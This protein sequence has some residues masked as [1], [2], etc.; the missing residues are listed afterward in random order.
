MVA[1]N[2]VGCGDLGLR[3]ALLEQ[4][5]KNTV[6]GV[7]RSEASALKLQKRNIFPIVCDLANPAN[8]PVWPSDVHFLYY[9]AP[10]TEGANQDRALPFFLSSFN[11]PTC[12]KKIVL[13]ST[14]G[15]YGDCQGA[16]VHEDSPTNPKN[17]RSILRLEAERQ[18]QEWSLKKS[19]SYTILR[20]PA[21]Y[22][23]GRLPLKR[24]LDRLPVV[25]EE[26]SGFSN[27]IHVDDLAHVCFQAA[28]FAPSGRIYN[29]SDGHPTKMTD[30]FYQ[31]ADFFQIPRPPALPLAQI[32]NQVSPTL[33]SYFLE[34]RRLENR[35]LREEL[36][37]HLQY[38]TLAEGLNACEEPH[39]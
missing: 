6:W 11:P 14:S 17:T 33:F 37:V 39:S 12:L 5:E 1:I 34:S 28:R 27:R 38:P 2:I 26:E 29:V 7:V 36:F 21:I 25:C 10:P 30:Y 13:I 22:G 35:R 9:L 24:L 15:V 18:L 23:P 32:Q 19:V 16:W 8:T 4:A 31:V 20:V 3:I